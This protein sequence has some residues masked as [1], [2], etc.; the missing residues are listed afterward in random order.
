MRLIK[1]ILH[2][3]LADDFVSLRTVCK[4]QHP[5]ELRICHMDTLY[6]V[7]LSELRTTCVQLSSLVKLRRVRRKP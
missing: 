3:H 2:L 5:G 6:S 1:L 4:M 7:T